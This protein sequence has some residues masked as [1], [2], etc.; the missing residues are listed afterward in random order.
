MIVKMG[1]KI[2]EKLGEG[3]YLSV[4]SFDILFKTSFLFGKRREKCFFDV[5][6]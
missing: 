3:L 2:A 6:M 5:I 1:R 4:H